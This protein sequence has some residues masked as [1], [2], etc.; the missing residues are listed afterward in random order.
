MEDWTLSKI[1]KDY[2]TVGSETTKAMIKKFIDLTWKLKP[3]LE[4]T[5]ENIYYKS[6]FFFPCQSF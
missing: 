2:T 5:F 3:D 1:E 6:S 4:D